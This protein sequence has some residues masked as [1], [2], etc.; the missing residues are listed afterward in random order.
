VTFK[1]HLPQLIHQSD[2]ELTLRFNRLARSLGV[3]AQAWRV[4]AALVDRNE[5]RV[6]ELAECTT[7]ELSTLSHLLTRMSSSGL[8]R[9]RRTGEDQRSVIVSV[10]SEGRRVAQELEPLAAHH[11]EIALEGFAEDEA[12][13]LKAMLRR[14]S[15]N[16]RSYA[17]GAN[18]KGSDARPD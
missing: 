5:Q 15:E 4:L 16:I 18:G 12:R 11:E 3:N 9:R 6:G 13:A 17:N 7:I 2:T 8:I 1:N 14:V 10:T